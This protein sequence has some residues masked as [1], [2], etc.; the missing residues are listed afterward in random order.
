MHI[1]SKKHERGKNRAEKQ[2]RQELSFIDALK[3]F[4]KEHHP[5]GKTLPATTRVYR[6]KVITSMLKA[7]VPLT[8]LACFRE[9]L[10]YI[11]PEAV[12]KRIPMPCLAFY[13]RFSCYKPVKTPS[14]VQYGNCRTQSVVSTHSAVPRALSCFDHAPRSTIPI[15]HTRRCSTNQ[16][17]LIH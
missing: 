11:E 9:W 13:D 10:E 14:L 17:H 2:N 16:L 1:K 12:R 4:D 6:V 3:H 7:G 5:V 15:L 8:M